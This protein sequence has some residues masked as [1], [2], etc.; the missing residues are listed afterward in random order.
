MSAV[1]IRPARMEDAAAIA[2]IYAPF[3]HETAI[4]FEIDAPDADAI[5]AR[6]AR[7]TAR[8]PFLVAERGGEV[9]GYAYAGRYRRRAAYDWVCESAIYV[10]RGRERGGIGQTLYEAL[11]DDLTERGYV[12]VVAVITVPNRQS[13]G[14]H[15][16]LGFEDRGIQRGIG[17][18]HGRW[19]DVGFWQL[20]L[21]PRRAAPAPP[22]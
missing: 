3:V 10:A 12:T 2:A 21:A 19:H 8:F 17:F 4:T 15:A 13:T 20:D 1:A 9:V 18:K 7:T 16:A 6:I 22:G 5:A 11:L 14:F